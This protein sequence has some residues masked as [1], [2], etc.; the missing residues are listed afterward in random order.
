MAMH[1]WKG[2]TL[3]E[4]LVVIA[5]IALLMSILMPAL[6]R[7]KR[8]ANE[9]ICQSNLKQW[10]LCFSMYTIDN[11]G[12]FEAGW[13]GGVTDNYWWVNLV[14]PYCGTEDDIRCCPMATRR[15]GNTR[16]TTFTA[17]EDF[18][19][20]G[21]HGRGSY[22][23]NGWVENLADDYDWMDPSKR[24]RNIAVKGTTEIP[25]LL[26]CNWIDGWPRTFDTPPPFS[27][28]PPVSY[29]GDYMQRFCLNRHNK[30]I[31]AVF[32]DFSHVRKVGLK[33]LWRLKWHQGYDTDASPPVWP[34]WMTK[35]KDCED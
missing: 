35:F 3:V 21:C 14:Q 29:E 1:K 25:L 27:D 28:A 13:G 15:D 12:Y 9:V 4:L 24:W 6:S 17:W 22:G 10:G 7:A 34:D 33:C 23:I 18:G 16:G 5:I 8:Q 31:Y 19:W 26:D 30:H 11:E 32:M 2:F 20:L